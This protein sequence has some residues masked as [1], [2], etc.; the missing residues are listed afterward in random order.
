MRFIKFYVYD[1][2]A[3][4]KASTQYI[5]EVRNLYNLEAKVDPDYLAI[6]LDFTYEDASRTVSPTSSHM[7]SND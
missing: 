6:R 2:N 4:D 3:I 5:Y 1:M 7:L